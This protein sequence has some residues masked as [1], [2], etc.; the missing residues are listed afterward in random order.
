MK[1]NEI[2]TPSSQPSV[3]YYARTELEQELRDVLDTQGSICSIAG[4]SKSGKTV[5]CETVIPNMLLVTGADLKTVIKF[6]EK[7]RQKL[8]APKSSTTLNSTTDG[9]ESSA[10]GE[11]SAGF[12]SFF[13]AK[14]GIGSK[15]TSTQQ[16][17]TTQSFDELSSQALFD[18]LRAQEITLVVDDFHYAAPDVQEALAQEFKE[19]ARN[20]LRIV[21][22]SVPHRA[23][24]PIR[25][26]LDLR[27]RLTTLDIPAWEDGEL[28]EIP[29]LGFQQ[30]NVTVDDTTLRRLVLE[31]LGSPQLIQT[32]C[33]RLCQLHSLQNPSPTPIQIQ[34]NA[35]ELA[36]LLRRAARSTNCDTVYQLLKTGPKPRGEQRNVYAYNAGKQGD[37][38]TL[39]LAAIASGE[40]ALTFNYA[41]IKARVSALI[42]A[43]TPEPRGVDLTNALQQ[44]DKLAADDRVLEFDE[45]TETLNI[46][47]PYF[48][49]YLR[50]ATK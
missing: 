1:A 35:A 33:L 19:A 4:P 43:N 49:Y 22:I 24:Q 18:V 42:D 40:A 10:T 14:A 3:T 2:F 34:L 37:V 15:S 32:L 8:V 27:G 29:R 36:N 50:W 45:E 17:S 16:Q 31:S 5:L 41:A 47:D 12:G 11:V 25:K 26:N 21:V 7:V 39:I 30:L 6:W 46:L 20:G 48:L 9:G 28:I 44:M 13:T 38:Y 23:D